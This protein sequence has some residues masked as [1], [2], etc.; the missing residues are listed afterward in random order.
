MTTTRLEISFVQNQ[1]NGRS[2]LL[3]T[4]SIPSFCA[5]A[6]AAAAI[7]IP[8]LPLVVALFHSNFFFCFWLLPLINPNRSVE[9]L[10]CGQGD[11]R[12]RRRRRRLLCFEIFN[13]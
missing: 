8:R 10:N 12:R 7:Y 5:A 1:I 13:F 9:T 6:A 2:R 3:L 4:G 11:R